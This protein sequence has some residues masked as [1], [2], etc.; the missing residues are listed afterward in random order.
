MKPIDDDFKDDLRDDDLRH[1]E[2]KHALRREPAPEGFAERVLLRVESARL[3][4]ERAA[5]T[6][7]DA[8]DSGL[9]AFIR[10]ISTRT[11]FARPFVRWA[12]AVALA[13]VVA[14]AG[15]EIHYRRVQYEN[16][17]RERAEGEAAKQRLM[18]A[19]RIAGSKLQLARSKVNQINVSQ[20][21]GAR[22][23]TEN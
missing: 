23:D 5:R 10:T 6:K 9:T 14:G 4:E 19:L 15:G 7:T 13:V 2:L 17:Q 3:E 8:H 1:D 12:T 16:A 20:R 22:T 21:S 11:V 18:L